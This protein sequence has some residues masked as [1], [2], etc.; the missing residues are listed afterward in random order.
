M[1]PDEEVPPGAELAADAAHDAAVAEGGAQVRAELAEESAESAAAA[2]E[3]ALAVAKENAETAAA[4]IEAQ[5]VATGAAE[6]SMSL[7]E[8]IKDMH[9]TQMAAIAALGEELRAARE[10]SK[11][12]VS[13]SSTNSKPDHSPGAAKPRWVRR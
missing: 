6:E 10:A 8:S 9:A 4:V 5:A 1:L 11:P 3:V 7:A 13:E 2:A 12:Q